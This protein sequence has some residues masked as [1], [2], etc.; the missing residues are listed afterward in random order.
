MGLR[1]PSSSLHPQQPE[2]ENEWEDQ[3]NCMWD[4]LVQL[5]QRETVSLLQTVSIETGL[6]A[7]A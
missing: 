5:E 2:T 4:E 3:V 1:F 6:W 7:Q